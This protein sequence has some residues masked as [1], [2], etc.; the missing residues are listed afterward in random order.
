MPLIATVTTSKLLSILTGSEGV[1]AAVAALSQ[2]QNV[3]LPPV[4]SQQI[5]A[6]NVAADIAERSSIASYPLIY[7]Y[8]NKVINQ[9]RE[10]FR[11]FSGETE[12]VVEA[13]ISQDRLDDMQTNVQLYT[14]AITQ[15]L[16]DN[17][18]DWG[19]GVFYGGGYEISF[20]GMKHGGRNFL[21][22]AKI[23]FAL[24]VSAD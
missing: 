17:R 11:T 1:P 22:T 8:C 14:G 23:S 24:Q 21:Q 3:S 15:V 7:V 20:A 2:A 10:K 6:Q 13:R 12:M 16:D 9:L 18:G 4:S 19:D 5:V